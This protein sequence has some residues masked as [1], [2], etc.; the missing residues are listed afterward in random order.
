MWFVAFN[1]KARKATSEN[2][3]KSF[4][5]VSW[6]KKAILRWHRLLTKLFFLL[7][8]TAARRISHKTL[9]TFWLAELAFLFF[10]LLTLTG[11]LLLI[12]YVPVVTQTGPNVKNSPTVIFAGQFLRGLHSFAAAAL[13]LSIGL[14]FIQIVLIQ[15]H[16][17]L[18][19]K[20]WTVNVLLVGLVLLLQV[21]G[22]LLP[23]NLLTFW[24]EVVSSDNPSVTPFVGPVPQFL[25][26]SGYETSQ[27]A[28]DRFMALHVI[29]LPL[30]FG[31]LTLLHFWQSSKDKLKSENQTL[32]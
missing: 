4:K 1:K 8:P 14:H 15:A 19:R 17:Y 30:A 31:G 3:G 24:S 12:Y 2:N 22:T 27:L 9:Y 25:L 21:T 7:N 18:R 5:S 6:L 11:G 13:L 29:L 20:Q 10:L 16:K 28:L 23:W 32:T 26:I